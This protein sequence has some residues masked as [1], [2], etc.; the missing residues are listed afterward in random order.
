MYQG[1]LSYFKMADVTGS[2]AKPSKRKPNDVVKSFTDEETEK[3]ITLWSKEPVLYYC[4]HKDYF[5]KDVRMVALEKMTQ[6][7]GKIGK[8]PRETKF[9]LTH[10][11]F[12]NLY[13]LVYISAATNFLEELKR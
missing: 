12:L 4:K 10:E 5:K 13:P 3:L 9:I 2:T 7:L 6:E 1:L 11:L 8:Q